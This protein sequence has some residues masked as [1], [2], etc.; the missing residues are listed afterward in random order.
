MATVQIA[1]DTTM[2]IIITVNPLNQVQVQGTLDNKISAFGLLEVAKE[3]IAKLFAEQ[4]KRI[5]PATPQFSMQLAKRK[6]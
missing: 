4:E 5:Q 6:Q 2:A 3:A 1:D